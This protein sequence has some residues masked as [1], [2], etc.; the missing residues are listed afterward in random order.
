MFGRERLVAREKVGEML[1]HGTRMACANC[2][3]PLKL[4][5][6]IEE[7]GDRSFELELNRA[8]ARRRSVQRLERPRLAHGILAAQ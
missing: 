3:G 4:R 6:A 5:P 2:G 8:A 1:I 7:T